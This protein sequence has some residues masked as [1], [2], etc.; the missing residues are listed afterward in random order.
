MTSSSNISLAGKIWSPRIA[1]ELSEEIGILMT[2]IIISLI[3]KG[4]RVLSI[5]E[6][7]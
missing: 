7:Q 2:I 6:S 1:K 4:C 5:L 3:A